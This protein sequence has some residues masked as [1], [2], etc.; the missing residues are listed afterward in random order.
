LVLP[1]MIMGSVISK[2]N[3]ISQEFF[4]RGIKVLSSKGTKI[5]F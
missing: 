3:K 5:F 2:L 1:T 4:F